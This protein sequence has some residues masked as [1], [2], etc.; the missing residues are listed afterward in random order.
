MTEYDDKEHIKSVFTKV[1]AA[2]M[3]ILHSWGM[4]ILPYLD[5]LLIKELKELSTLWTLSELCE[6]DSV[7]LFVVNHPHY[8]STVEIFKFAEEENVLVHLKTIKHSALHNVNDIVAVGPESFYATNDFY[9]SDFIMRLI[10]MVF[11]LRLTNV[12]YYSP[13]EVREVAADFTTQMGSPCLLTKSICSSLLQINHLS[14]APLLTAVC[15]CSLEP[16]YN[17]SLDV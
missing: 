6:D 8:K 14:I 16:P 7:Y 1:M 2:F 5:D 15:M 4:I 3:S 17:S 13:G 11:G 10:E 9:F 12:V